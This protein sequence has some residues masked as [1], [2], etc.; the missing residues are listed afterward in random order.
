[1]EEV[2]Y[3]FKSS[4]L[5]GS[6]YVLYR[7]RFNSVVPFNTLAVPT[8]RPKWKVTVDQ[9]F[10]T[11]DSNNLVQRL[12]FIRMFMLTTKSGQ[13]CYNLSWKPWKAKGIRV[14]TNGI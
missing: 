5:I 14:I 4:L 13:L 2:S 6:L 8:F 3:N 9:C 7:W 12:D 1:M 11:E 10:L